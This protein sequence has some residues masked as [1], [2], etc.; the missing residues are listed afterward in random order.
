MSP[1]QHAYLA[2]MLAIVDRLPP[3]PDNILRLRR[4][5]GD[6]NASFDD[7]AAIIERDPGLAADVL[8]IANSAYFSVGHQVESIPEAVRYIGFRGV[9]DYVTIAFSKRVVKEFFKDIPDLFDYF[10]HSDDVSRATTILA[11]CAGRP[12]IMQDFYT[13]TGLLHDI[14]RLVIYLVSDAKILHA[15]RH[16]QFHKPNLADKEKELLGV[17]H[18]FI[19]MKLCEKWAFSQQLQTA[20]LKHH[21]PL[22]NGYYEDAAF[23]LLGHFISMSDMSIEQIMLLFPMNVYPLMGLDREKI[24]QARAMFFSRE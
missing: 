6:Q 15:L 13:V 2:E 21:S 3:L 18:C 4:S 14:G 1:E 17:N 22:S 11:R 9:A 5:C 12:R 7:L 10:K 19:G 24:E 20:V 23:V 8:H 16:E